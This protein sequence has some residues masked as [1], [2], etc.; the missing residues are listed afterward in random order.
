MIAYAVKFIDR[1]TVATTADTTSLWRR[2]LLGYF[3]AVR[4]PRMSPGIASSPNAGT[5]LGST[6][7]YSSASPPA[8]ATG[9]QVEAKTTEPAGK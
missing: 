7:L 9:A 6:R 3:L 1:E 8:I 2:Y 5:V 4:S